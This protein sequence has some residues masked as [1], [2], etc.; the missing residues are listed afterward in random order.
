[1]SF[2]EEQGRQEGWRTLLAS[3]EELLEIRMLLRGTF[4]G[5]PVGATTSS[6]A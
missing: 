5:R 1:M 4:T 6:T 2:W 3:P